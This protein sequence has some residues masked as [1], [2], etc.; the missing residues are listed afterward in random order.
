MDESGPEGDVLLEVNCER[1]EG[2]RDAQRIL[3]DV[4]ADKKRA[5]S[6]KVW[7]P[8]PDMDLFVDAGGRLALSNLFSKPQPELN[9]ISLYAIAAEPKSRWC[10]RA[11]ASATAIST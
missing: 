6:L 1:C 7:Q 8:P 3:R 2:T 5:V 9:Q 10:C 11:A 4:F